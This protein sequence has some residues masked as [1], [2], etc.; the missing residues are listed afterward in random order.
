MAASGW[1]RKGELM[2]TYCV[3]VA[4]HGPLKVLRSMVSEQ[5]E[6]EGRAHPVHV[7]G[8]PCRHSPRA[9]DARRV[10]CRSRGT[11]LPA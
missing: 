1:K 3:D 10:P 4:M 2:L 8:R 6:E 7:A 11:S 9:A 5:G